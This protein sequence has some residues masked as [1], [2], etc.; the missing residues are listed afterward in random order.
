MIDSM[1][2]DV[3]Y[4]SENST[5]SSDFNTYSGDGAWVS[6]ARQT[7]GWIPYNPDYNPNYYPNQPYNSPT[8]PQQQP[9]WGTG[10]DTSGGIVP[11][12][13]KIT[14][15]ESEAERLEKSILARP[16]NVYVDSSGDY[17]VDLLV[18]G[19][20]RE[21]IGVESV[22]QRVIVV[23]SELEA[24]FVTEIDDNDYRVRDIPSGNDREEFDVPDEYVVEDL[25]AKR[26]DDGIL[27]MT[28]RRRETKKHGVT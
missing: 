24:D 6:P 3:L 19:Y 7:D 2:H 9:G 27:R 18:A 23:L 25:V 20:R 4:R 11:Y 14:T 12:T 1:R 10:I 28:F 8:I 13:I 21:Q 16:K 26:Y 17:H 5:M 15:A 22:G